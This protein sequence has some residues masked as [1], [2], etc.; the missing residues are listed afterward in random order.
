MDKAQDESDDEDIEVD[1]DGSDSEQSDTHLIPG[2][3]KYSVSL[4]KFTGEN[5]I[6]FFSL[7]KSFFWRRKFKV[8]IAIIAL[9][10]VPDY[11]NCFSQFS[12]FPSLRK[13]LFSC[14]LLVSVV[15]LPLVPLHFRSHLLSSQFTLAPISSRP[16]PFSFPSLLVPIYSRPHLHSSQFILVPISS[17]HNLFSFPSPLVL[18]CSHSR[19]HQ[20]KS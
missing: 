16:N 12:C 5:S 4:W 17:C 11:N 19:L 2:N 9:G 20:Q 15:F 6:L 14:H 8:Q 3:L 1:V 7:S 18:V 10:W 13:I